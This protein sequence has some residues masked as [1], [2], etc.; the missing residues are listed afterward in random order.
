MSGPSGLSARA[1]AL[2][3]EVKRI[4]PTAVFTSGARSASHN[5]GIPGASKGSQHIH[6]DAFDFQVPGMDPRKVQSVIAASGLTY[7]QNIAEYG[8]GMGPRNHLSVTGTRANGRPIMGENL[9]AQNGKYN[10]N[11]VSIGDGRDWLVKNWGGAIGNP[12]ADA[13]EGFGDMLEAPAKGLSDV[14]ILGDVVNNRDMSLDGWFNRI[15]LV[16]FALIFIAAAVFAFK[17]S[18]AIAMISKAGGK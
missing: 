10:S 3:L 16:V 13:L 9:I 2:W 14:P 12:I 8:L 11:L 17:G 5:A 6:G 4:F 18:D 15:A 7:G 1:Y